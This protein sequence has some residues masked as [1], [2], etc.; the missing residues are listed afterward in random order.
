[1]CWKVLEVG[2]GIQMNLTILSKN[3][4][5]CAIIIRDEVFS[6]E[7]NSFGECGGWGVLCS[8]VLLT[9]EMPLFRKK[10]KADFQE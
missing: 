10:Q 7:I 9:K 8:G 5:F 2:R 6:Q 4:R 3:Y 1:M